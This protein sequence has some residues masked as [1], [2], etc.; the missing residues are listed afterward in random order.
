MTCCIQPGVSIVYATKLLVG[1][2]TCSKMS[3][4]LEV[5]AMRVATGIA[6]S[7][8][9]DP[10]SGTKILLNMAFLLLLSM[11]FCYD[12]ESKGQRH[13]FSVISNFLVKV[14]FFHL[15]GISHG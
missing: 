10:S 1:D 15:T 9:S 2:A 11:P 3:D 12:I 7:A 4:A 8:R 13:L 6:R 14:Y 5:R